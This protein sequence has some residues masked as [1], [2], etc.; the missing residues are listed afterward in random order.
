MLKFKNNMGGFSIVETLVAISILLLAVVGPMSVAEQGLSSARY[1]ADQITA[2]YLAQEAIEYVRNTRDENNLAEIDWLSGLD[3][4]VG[5][6]WCGIGLGLNG[7]TYEIRA[8]G[9]IGVGDPCLLNINKGA[10]NQEGKY[11]YTPN[12]G[13]VP[14]TYTRRVNVSLLNADEAV[15]SVYISWKS[16]TIDR[17]FTIRENILNWRKQN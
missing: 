7:K 4:C 10:N 8:C 1:A 2:Y 12:A 9:P 3:L 13:W 15:I 14:S 17:Q 6:N 11:G 16:K 5:G